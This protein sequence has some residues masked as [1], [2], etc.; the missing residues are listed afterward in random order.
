MD[1]CTLILIPAYNEA[2][3]IG[4][5]LGAITERDPSAPIL[6]V[7]D[8]SSDGTANAARAAGARVIS[9]PVNLGYGAA[10]QTGYR[11][12]LRENFA[13]VIQLDADGQHDPDSMGRIQQKL[14]E[15]YDLVLGSRFLDGGSYRP[16]FARRIG[17]RIFSLITGIVLGRHISDATTGYQGLSRRMFAFYDRRATFPH[18][19][20]DANIIIRAARAGHRLVE[21]PV[22]MRANPDG[23]TLHVGWKPVLYVV[24]MIFAI[25]VELT[26][27]LPRVE[28][29]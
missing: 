20:P 8:G 24:K 26:R 25:L 28:E 29:E 17:I 21:V 23:G 5:L 14:D 7:D 12:A 22:L 15:G 11:Y 9:H 19:Y 10:L 27:R 13:R 16:P 18:D 1:A 2:R 3:T 6:V 4:G